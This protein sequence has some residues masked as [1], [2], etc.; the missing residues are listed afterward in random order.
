MH[1]AT[2]RV[3]APQHAQAKQVYR[4]GRWWRQQ[5]TRW[6]PNSPAVL[7]QIAPQWK[8][9]A[10]AGEKMLRTR[11]HGGVALEEL[12]ELLHALSLCYVEVTGRAPAEVRLHVRLYLSPVPSRRKWSTK[13]SQR[14]SGGKGSDSSSSSEDRSKG[15]MQGQQRQQRGKARADSNGAV[16]TQDELLSG[17]KE[18]DDHSEGNSESMRRTG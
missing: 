17:S 6:A 1:F 7:I 13:I 18:T 15:S 8:K 16:P 12:Q 11:A 3:L 10:A 5:V 14:L 9:F 2:G 4:S